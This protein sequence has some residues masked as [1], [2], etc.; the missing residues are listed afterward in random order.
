MNF[1]LAFGFVA[2]SVGLL[3]LEWKRS[4]RRNLLLRSVAT[5]CATG[6]LGMLMDRLPR[7]NL[8]SKGASE[9][10]LWTPGSIDPAAVPPVALV[11]ALPG[12]PP[13]APARAIQIPDVGTLRR[14]YPN[15]RTLHLCGDGLAADELPA[16][17]GLHV[18]SHPPVPLEGA[19]SA[20]VF[21]SCPRVITLGE[22]LRVSGRMAGLPSGGV[23]SI[24]LEGPDGR[25]TEVQVGPA[26]TRGGSSFDLHAG[27]PPAAGRYQ[28]HLR[29]G[30]TD[31]LI[32]VSVVPP[33]LPRVLVLEAAPRFDSASLRRWYAAAGGTMVIRT[34]TGKDLFRYAGSRESVQPFGAVD[35]ALLKGFDLVFADWQAV[36]ALNEPE[37]AALAAA[38]REAGLGL[39]VQ[40]DDA[41]QPAAVSSTPTA[42]RPLLPWTLV[43]APAV[44]S[45]EPRQA[46]L[47]W[48]GQTAVS[49]IPL[50]IGSF[51]V[52]LAPDE[53]PL[54]DDRQ[55]QPLVTSTYAG[56]GQLALSLVNDTS[57]LL[58][59]NESAVFAAYWSFLFTRLS[60]PHTDGAG[61][62]AL[63]AGE[64]GPVFVNHPLALRW[65][66]PVNKRPETVRVS[67]LPSGET[68]SLAMAQNASSLGTWHG[69]FWPRAAGWYRVA[70]AETDGTL[71]FYVHPTMAWPEWQAVA[72][73]YATARFVAETHA[74]FA[75]PVVPAARM[76]QDLA[77]AWFSLFVLAVGFLWIEHRLLAPPSHH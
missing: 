48:N 58:R 44:A 18:L 3:I 27:S 74:A 37:A 38:I 16:L 13:N 24:S 62:W 2:G 22:T 61:R 72:R 28:W 15:V 1:P 51:N 66:G 41:V 39:L 73:H 54:V 71:D 32:G 75:P 53:R 45:P 9:A 49:E 76:V 56:R 10:V 36:A 60:R 33:R 5:V 14:R 31:E 4:D 68:T 52:N 35:P 50:P 25:K 67:Q 46:R 65:S 11:F 55:G 26:D 30:N 34:Q 8:P 69:T 17:A 29:A 42:A 63:D 70:T 20:V 64:R 21:L 47:R 23:L 43:A 6:A 57:R 59:E 77:Y 40:V 7:Q 19:N 12:A